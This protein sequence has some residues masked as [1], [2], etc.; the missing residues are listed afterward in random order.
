MEGFFIIIF[1]HSLIIWPMCPVV[2][3]DAYIQFETG[4]LVSL[5]AS[6]PAGRLHSSWVLFFRKASPMLMQGILAG[7]VNSSSIL[8][9]PFI[10]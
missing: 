3:K 7:I 2:L 8:Y 10:A 4:V 1:S 6:S 5:M 9:G